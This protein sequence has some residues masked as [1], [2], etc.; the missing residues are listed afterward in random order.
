MTKVSRIETK[1]ESFENKLDGI[2]DHL[3]IESYVSDEDGHPQVGITD[4]GA[5]DVKKR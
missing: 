1:V 3:G 5:F 4:D 2:S